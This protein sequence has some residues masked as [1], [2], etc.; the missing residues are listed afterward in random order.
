MIFQQ[1]YNKILQKKS[2][3][4]LNT[5]SFN[6]QQAYEFAILNNT[7]RE[8]YSGSNG[9]IQALYQIQ[10][11]LKENNINFYLDSFIKNTPIGKVKFNNLLVD[12][13]SKNSNEFIIIGCH[14]DTK[15]LPQFKNFSGANDG[16]SGVGL[17]LSLILYFNQYKN[18]LPIG[19][20]FIF[21]DGEECYYEYNSTDGLFGSKHA[22][23]VLH[24]NCKYMILAD[25]IGAKNLKIQFPK[26]SNIELINMTLEIAKNNNYLNYFDLNLSENKIIDDTNPFE[27]FGIPTLN[28]IQMSYKYWHTNE[29]TIDKLSKQSFN[30]IGN[31]II[32]LIFQLFDK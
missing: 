7:F 26:N 30:I 2:L 28:F 8:R 1:I 11:I 14:H 23:K 31:T 10:S 20:K 32:Q 18:N 6:Y 16:S 17:L 3:F 15:L 13:P 19:L 9:N 21:F 29:D 5:D 24:N 25:M 22:A 12:F 4:L 27:K